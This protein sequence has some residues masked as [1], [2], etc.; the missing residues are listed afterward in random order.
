MFPDWPGRSRQL[1]FSQPQSC[2]GGPWPGRSRLTIVDF[3]SRA[4]IIAGSDCIRGRD[5]EGSE[6]GC[7]KDGTRHYDCQKSLCL[8]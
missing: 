8:L 4:R 6:Q 3:H 7:E 1:P 2:L 5:E